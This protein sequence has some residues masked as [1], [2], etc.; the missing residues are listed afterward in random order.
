MKDEDL[1]KLIDQQNQLLA[2]NA[3]LDL[4]IARMQAK[5]ARIL[6]D[7][8]ELSPTL[9]QEL[10]KRKDLENAQS[11]NGVPDLVAAE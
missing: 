5:K 10:Q 2:L 8:K 4:E 1:Q 9:S 3:N 7:L 11:P 6:E